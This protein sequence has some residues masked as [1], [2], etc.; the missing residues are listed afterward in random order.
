MSSLTGWCQKEKPIKEKRPP[1]PLN[2]ISF[3]LSAT[4][5]NNY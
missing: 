2:P 1:E 3:R 4:D 5:N